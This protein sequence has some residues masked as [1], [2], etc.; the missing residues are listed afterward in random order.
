MALLPLLFNLPIEIWRIAEIMGRPENVQRVKSEKFSFLVGGGW[1]EG[2]GLR[3]EGEVVNFLGEG[4]YPSA[5]YG[6]FHSPTL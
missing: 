4:S 1:E 5:Y 2:R 3:Y 6:L